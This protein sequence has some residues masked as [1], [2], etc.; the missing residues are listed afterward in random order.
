M[1][2]FVKRPNMLCLKATCLYPFN[3]KLI[4]AELH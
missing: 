4:I 3:I 1:C 2:D